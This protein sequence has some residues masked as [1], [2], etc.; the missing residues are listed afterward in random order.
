MAR[1]LTYQNIADY[2]PAEL[3][4]EGR[5]EASFGRPEMKG[6][7]II[8]GHSGNGKTR[9]AMQLAK[10]LCRFGRVAYDSLEEGLSKSMQAAVVQSGM[11]EVERRFLLLDMEGKEDL[12]RRLKRRKS[13]DVVIID[14][15]QYSRI[16]MQ[17]Y[18]RMKRLF[19]GKLFVFVSHASGTEPKGSVAS[20]IRYDASVKV[21]VEGYRAYA[22]SRYKGGEAEPFEIWREGA[23]RYWANRG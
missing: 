20:S 11:K 18:E 23:E 7:W 9:F 15:L 14:S 10:Y 2:K 16:V 8:W 1:A 6:S 3:A 21:W 19:P 13:P 5:W 4:F 12:V 17:D 22:V